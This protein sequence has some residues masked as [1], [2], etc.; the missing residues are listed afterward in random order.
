M[1]KNKGRMKTLR[2]AHLFT[3]AALF[4]GLKLAYPGEEDGTAKKR[5]SRGTHV[6]PLGGIRATSLLLRGE[7]T[8]IDMTP[9][10][11]S[12]LASK[13]SCK[14]VTICS[15]AEA[16]YVVKRIPEACL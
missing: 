12:F 3:K 16:L 7:E 15:M 10:A 8:Q 11:H 2:E 14:P 4:H 5:C 1:G 13:L 6:V 9:D